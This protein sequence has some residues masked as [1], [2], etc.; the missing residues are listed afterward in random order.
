MYRKENCPSLLKDLDA[1][2]QTNE[3]HSDEEDQRKMMWH[4]VTYH[5]A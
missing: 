3:E 2:E 1:N 4:K 5:Y